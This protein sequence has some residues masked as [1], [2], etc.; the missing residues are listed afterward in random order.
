LTLGLALLPIGLARTIREPR[1]GRVARSLVAHR[2][3]MIVSG[4][5]DI[6]AEAS[7]TAGDMVVADVDL[8]VLSGLRELWATTVTE[9]RTRAGPVADAS[10]CAL[11]PKASSARPVER[12]PHAMS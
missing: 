1:T 10:A 12:S 2:A 6:L 8:A 4:R 9:G 3:S 5:G 11:H 7:A